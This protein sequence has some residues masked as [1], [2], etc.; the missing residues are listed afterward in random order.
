MKM[1]AGGK[2]GV[3]CLCDAALRINVHAFPDIYFAEMTVIAV[4]TAWMFNDD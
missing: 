2:P 4:V 1:R 3:A